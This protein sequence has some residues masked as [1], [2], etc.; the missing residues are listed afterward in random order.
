MTNRIM[1]QYLAGIEIKAQEGS[2]NVPMSLL[3]ENGDG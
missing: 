2:I 3:S 1:L